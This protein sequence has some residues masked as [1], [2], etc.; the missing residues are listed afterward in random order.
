MYVDIVDILRLHSSIFEGSIHYECCTETFWVSSS[1]V[2]S[3]GRHTATDNLSIYLGTTSLCMLKFLKHKAA[4]AFAHD[5]TI[6]A[7]AEWTAR[8]HHVFV[9]CRESLHS[10]ETADASLT[11]S[12]LSTTCHHDVGLAKTEKVVC[13]DH[14]MSRRSASRYC[15]VVWSVETI[16]DT[17]LTSS[18]IGN[19]LRDEEWVVLRT[20]LRIVAASLLLESLDTTDTSAVDDANTVLVFSLKVNAAILDSLSHSSER[21]LCIAVNLAHLLLVEVESRIEILYLASKLGLEL[22]S[23][24]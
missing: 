3:I 1:E 22:F 9:A 24:E 13:I 6:A 7:C 14:A 17:D 23:V 8:T 21:Q 19:H 18:N 20:N 4:R 2:I 16:V 5:E 10:V 11:D 15:A 12:S